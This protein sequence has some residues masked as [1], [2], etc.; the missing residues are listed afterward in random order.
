MVKMRRPSANRVITLLLLL[1]PLLTSA[2]ADKGTIEPESPFWFKNGTDHTRIPL[3][4]NNVKQFSHGSPP[5]RFEIRTRTAEIA[6]YSS[7]FA[8]LLL[9]EP[10]VD[11][12]RCLSGPPPIYPV[13]NPSS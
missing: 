6:R 13:G 4:A 12:F 11:R 1:A 7:T 2:Q 9:A 10:F 8:T 3:F 5:S